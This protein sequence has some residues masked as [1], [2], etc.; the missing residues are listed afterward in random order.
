MMSS[1]SIL[2]V[3]RSSK[4]ASSRRGDAEE[5][6]GELP[7]FAEMSVL[8]PGSLRI[9]HASSYVVPKTGRSS[10]STPVTFVIV[11]WTSGASAERLSR[12]GD[13][14]GMVVSRSTANGCTG[15]P[16]INRKRHLP[17]FYRPG[18]LARSLSH[19]RPEGTA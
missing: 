19:P 13:L 8:S 4:T 7:I 2:V 12:F 9:E 3:M 1:T 18:L 16:Y 6:S 14:V 17:A 10:A 11:H 15:D 5:R